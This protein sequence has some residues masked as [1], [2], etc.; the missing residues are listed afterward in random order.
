[1]VTVVASAAA[2]GAVFMIASATILVR[3]RSR[4]R[5]NRLLT[6]SQFSLQSRGSGGFGSGSQFI[7]NPLYG[8]AVPTVNS[9]STP[10][11]IRNLAELRSGS[12]SVSMSPDLRPL[13]NERAE[14]RQQVTAPP[15]VS[16][17]QSNAAA[18]K[19]DSFVTAMDFSK[20]V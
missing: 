19:D 7:D 4:H 8:K 9:M 1:M 17:S 5:R 12:D 16:K 13:V 2:V 6:E 20:Y 11:A 3:R 18:N 14:P 15:I 10:P